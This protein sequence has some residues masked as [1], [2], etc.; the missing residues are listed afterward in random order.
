MGAEA[1]FDILKRLDL[2][3]LSEELWMEVRT[4]KSKQKRKKATTRLKVVEAFRR[5]KNRPEW[6]V[7][8]VL[9]VI[10]PDLAT[11]GSTGWW[12]FCNF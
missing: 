6:M 1:Y 9:P 5:S 2:D 3:K 11:N 4:S 10:P 8:T 7:M 12:T